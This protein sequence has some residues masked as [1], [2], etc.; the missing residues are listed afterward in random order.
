MHIAPTRPMPADWPY[1]GMDP[2]QAR[3]HLEQR[4]AL[5]RRKE[6][7]DREQLSTW[8]RECA[9]RRAQAEARS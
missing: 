3:R 4:E 9:A 5:R 1:A 2:L 7:E 6:R 8:L